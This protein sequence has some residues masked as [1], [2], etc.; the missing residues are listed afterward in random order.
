MLA[1]EFEA[2]VHT[3][4]RL[5]DVWAAL[6]D[7]ARHC[8]VRRIVYHHLPPPGA[9]D[10]HLLR[11]ENSGFGDVLLHQYLS[12]R[13]AGIAVLASV[14]Q[15][16]VRPVYLDELDRYVSLSPRER[17]QALVSL[18]EALDRVL[19]T[20]AVVAGDAVISLGMRLMID[21]AAGVKRRMRSCTSTKIVA[22]PVPASRLFMSLAR[23]PTRCVNTLRS[24]WPGR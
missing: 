22:M 15:N 5:E 1:T 7:Y 17:A 4:T 21:E 23:S 9:P 19:E 13:E 2:R 10:A 8:S 18:C 24:V 3:M 16:S 12:A 14:I 20:G 6:V 11:I